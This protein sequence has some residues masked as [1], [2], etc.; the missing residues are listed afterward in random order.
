MELVREGLFRQ[1]LFFRLNVVN[2]NIPSLR[3]RKDDI[4]L[5]VGVFL[6]KYKALINRP[7]LEIAAETVRKLEQYDWPGNIREMENMIE[8]LVNVVEGDIITPA[9]LPPYLSETVDTVECKQAATLKELEID[10]ICRTIRHCQGNLR[11]A[12]ELLGIGRS[13]LYR[14]IKEFNIEINQLLN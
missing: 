13:T 4:G 7:N 6:D 1:D 8:G 12:A 3:A 11:D 14:K 9:D 10:A 2:V 5:L